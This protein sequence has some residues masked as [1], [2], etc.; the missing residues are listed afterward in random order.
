MLYPTP[1]EDAVYS[2]KLADSMHLTLVDKEGVCTPLNHNSGILYARAVQNQDGTLQAKSLRNPWIF[3]MSDGSFGVIAG[4]LRL[5]A[6]R[7]KVQKESCCFL[8]LRIC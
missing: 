8:H 7:M 4:G 6:A 2:A 5:T 1:M 3:G